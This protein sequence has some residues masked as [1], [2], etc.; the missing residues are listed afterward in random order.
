MKKI[1]VLALAVLCC[2]CDK[3]SKDDRTSILM[4]GECRMDIRKGSSRNGSKAG[5]DIVG[6]SIAV[7]RLSRYACSL[8]GKMNDSL[9]TESGRNPDVNPYAVPLDY[10]FW[11]DGLGIY[12]RDTVNHTFNFPN[13]IAISFHDYYINEQGEQM[14]VRGTEF[15]GFLFWLD[16][17]IFRGVYNPET[18]SF[19]FSREEREKW[20]GYPHPSNNVVW[21][22]LGYIPSSL[23]REN[24]EI[25]KKMLAEQRYQ[26]VLE[27]FKTAFHIYA[28]T[29]EEYRE[30]VRQGLN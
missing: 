2:A 25:V 3:P 8:S 4:F 26:D 27:F 12:K 15:P 5:L 6:D 30:L 20:G 29:G 10:L 7:H 16:Y 9:A 13:D 28:C 11:E 18:Q 17:P 14:G 1:I 21:D 23:M 19:I 22:T 24:R